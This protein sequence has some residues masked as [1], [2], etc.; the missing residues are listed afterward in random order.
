[1]GRPWPTTGGGGMVNEDIRQF[2]R[3]NVLRAVL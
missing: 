1:M 2:K 3:M